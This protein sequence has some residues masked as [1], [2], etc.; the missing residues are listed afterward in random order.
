MELKR[1]GDDYQVITSNGIVFLFS[2]LFLR[3]QDNQLRGN[4][5]VFDPNKELPVF[6]DQFSLSSSRTRSSTAKTLAETVR[7]SQG[8]LQEKSYWDNMLA[9]VCGFV[10]DA[11]NQPADVIDLSTVELDNSPRWLLK[12]YIERG[13][14]TTIFSRGDSL[15]SVLALGMGASVATGVSIIGDPLPIPSPVVY[16]DWEDNQQTHA[17]RLQAICKGHNLPLV[18][19]IKYIKMRNSLKNDIRYIKEVVDR[20]QAE[21]VIIDSLGIST[22]G[23]PSNTEATM[24]S[25]SSA[26]SLGVS[27]IIVHHITRESIKEGTLV[28]YG[29]AY[30]D[31][32]SRIMYALMKAKEAEAFQPVVGIY[33]KKSNNGPPA[34]GY[35]YHAL[36]LNFINEEAP[37]G[38][39]LLDKIKITEELMDSYPSLMEHV[40]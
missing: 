34:V 8:K 5:K 1:L 19:H 22:G 18:P 11:W 21:L 7:N 38:D 14:I 16:L 28:S 10:E 2:N 29:S 23:D 4:M 37:N 13:N 27:V 30:I 39:Y 33:P 9:E 36:K 24:H 17:R 25:L 20:L 32:E 35:G 3:G 40:F 26:L 6:R 31:N 15:K 12:P